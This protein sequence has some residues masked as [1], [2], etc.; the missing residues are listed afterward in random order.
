MYTQSYACAINANASNH[1]RGYVVRYW[2]WRKQ[3]L[4]FKYLTQQQFHSRN[5]R[6]VIALTPALWHHGLHTRFL[7]HVGCGHALYC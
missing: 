7:V 6:T 5:Q 4:L 1:L 3:T 2:S